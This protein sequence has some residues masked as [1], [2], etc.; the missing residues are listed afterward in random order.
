MLPVAVAWS[1]VI[2]LQYIVYMYFGFVDDVMFSYSGLCGSVMVLNYVYALILF[3]VGIGAS[4][5]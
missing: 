1:S 5:I 4:C 2:M 3:L